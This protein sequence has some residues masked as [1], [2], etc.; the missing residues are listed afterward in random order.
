MEEA[1]RRARSIVER[2]AARGEAR[3]SAEQKAS[4]L[5]EGGVGGGR[6]QERASRFRCV[7]R[8]RTPWAWRFRSMGSIQVPSSAPTLPARTTARTD[9]A[10]ARRSA[11][12][13]ECTLPPLV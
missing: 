10:P 5:V 13:R 1:E 11:A 2:D 12:A 6:L 3:A 7:G 4:R 9:C 8:Q